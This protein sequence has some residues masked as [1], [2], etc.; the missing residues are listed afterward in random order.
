MTT[1]EITISPQGEVR[2][3]TKGF[4]GAT[5]QAASRAWEQALGIRQS[6]QLTS[7]YFAASHEHSELRT[8]SGS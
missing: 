1:I 2:L 4:S 5:C 6:E 3:E 7:E 8:T